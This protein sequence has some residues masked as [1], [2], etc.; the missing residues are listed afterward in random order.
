MSDGL[1]YS[2]FWDHLEKANYVRR[3]VMRNVNDIS[4]YLL[5][6]RKRMNEKYT[7]AFS[8]DRVKLRLKPDKDQMDLDFVESGFDRKVLG[9]FEFDKERRSL[10]IKDTK[11]PENNIKYTDSNGNIITLK[12]K[13]ET[14]L[15]NFV[16]L[17]GNERTSERFSDLLFSNSA[18]IKGGH[19]I[20]KSNEKEEFIEISGYPSNDILELSADTPQLKRQT[21]ALE[22]LTHKPQK[23]HRALINLLI[24]VW[25]CEWEE[26]K[27]EDRHCNIL[28]NS[29]SGY[30]EQVE[31]VN[32]AMGS[33]D[34]SILFGPPGSG[35][36]A[37]IIELITQ[38]VSKG[39]K[40]L[41]V[42]ST[43]VAIDN[44]LERITEPGSDNISVADRYGIVPVRIGK[45]DVIS[46]KVSD[47]IFENKVSSE[48]QHMIKEL[49]KKI[50]RSDA[51][52]TLYKAL[53]ENGSEV[54]EKMI[55]DTSN[56]ICGTTIGIVNAPMIKE[57]SGTFLFDLMIID[58]AS[59]TTFPEFLVPALYAKKWVISGD[60]YQ[61]APYVDEETIIKSIEEAAKSSNVSNEVKEICVYGFES[62][63]DNQNPR[64]R[65]TI[66]PDDY[67]FF[68]DAA[69]HITRIEKEK[70]KMSTMLAI[71]KYPI[72]EG[73]LR[74]IP[75]ARSIIVR[76]GLFRYIEDFISPFSVISNG[77]LT[78][79]AERQKEYLMKKLK[80]KTK[81]KMIRRSDDGWEYNTVWRMSRMYE[82]YKSDNIDKTEDYENEI[83]LLM[84]RMNSVDCEKIKNDIFAISRIA[85][86][87][88][89][90]LLE[91]GIKRGQ[92]GGN[93]I[94]LFE[95]LGESRLK[96]RS[97]ELSYQHRMHP[98]ISKFPREHIYGDK[99]L[100]DGKDI[101]SQR[102]LPSFN[103][104]SNV[105]SI[106]R[107]MGSPDL[108]PAKNENSLEVRAMLEELDQIME[109][110]KGNR[111]PE[112]VWSVALLTFYRG[113]ES[114]IKSRLNEKLNMNKG[115]YFDLKDEY[116][117]EI[118][119]GT[120]DRF[121][122]HEA[123][124]VILSFVRSKR[125]RTVGFLD[126]RS[127]LNVAIT[128]A[129]F[130]LIVLADKKFFLERGSSLLKKFMEA[131][132]Q[133]F[134]E[135]HMG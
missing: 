20:I 48:L 123:D 65:I 54:M 78:E 124:F 128:R 8:I 118:Q 26:V 67:E 38:A 33:Q 47:Y 132:D 91:K 49:S 57:K 113:Q 12:V 96:E 100:K 120:V 52:E 112:G 42:A 81:Q 119:I 121:Q 99:A 106:L 111:K 66:V 86:P 56:L 105:R 87:S 43:H 83:D 84:P 1:F 126:N 58:E 114:L 107:D 41:L 97:V 85:L 60:P 80:E 36:T 71:D 94:T 89:M 134:E 19:H 55:I 11:P 104:Y 45:E 82:M 30:E 10:I 53:K 88:I 95:G 127:R 92:K 27:P 93:G 5:D 40:V 115:R 21:E 34:F 35:K 117:L 18:R 74:L 116:N 28:N 25:E 76:E 31:F 75:A 131:M 61:L 4:Q 23:Q 103:R 90:D 15:K 46:E 29:Y 98:D 72:E 50:N 101:I 108:D 64:C 73:T 130:A 129:R 13:I 39:E 102:D 62:V 69:E 63:S 22:K 109:W 24:P 3:E 2:I 135:I 17:E 122:G 44:I 6:A 37:T 125:H 59:K 70:E 133:K 77:K 32:K 110:T 68:D 7:F 14:R 16:C 79:R 9:D 51:Q